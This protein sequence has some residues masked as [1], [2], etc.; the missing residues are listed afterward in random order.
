[1]NISKYFTV[2]FVVFGLLALAFGGIGTWQLY[3]SLKLVITGVKTE[4]E[5]VGFV[6]RKRKS[7]IIYYPTVKFSVPDYGMQQVT[8]NHGYSY[9]LSYKI[10]DTISIFYD[11]NDTKQVK[12]NTIFA[13]FLFPFFSL[14]A[15]L[16]C[17]FVAKMGNIKPDWDAYNRLNNPDVPSYLYP[18]QNDEK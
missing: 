4:A 11:K 18:R 5:V 9:F 2:S 16:I 7:S 14:A 1:M 10:G 12:A 13:L 6:E 17:A 3:D 15:A 8:L